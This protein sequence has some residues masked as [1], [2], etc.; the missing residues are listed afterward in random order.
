MN[1]RHRAGGIRVVLRVCLNAE[2]APRHPGLGDVRPKLRHEQ[3]GRTRWR[4]P[5]GDMGEAVHFSEQFQH[6]DFGGHDFVLA[7]VP[8]GHVP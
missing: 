3:A 4:L 5:V 2:P 1:N 7:V 6:F 8:A